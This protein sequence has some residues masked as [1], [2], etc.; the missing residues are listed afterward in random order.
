MPI[1]PM[2]VEPYLIRLVGKESWELFGNF[3]VC[4]LTRRNVGDM[5]MVC[6]EAAANLRER[7][8]LVSN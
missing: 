2:D 6:I 4:P 5:Q 3:K 7:A 8:S 1:V